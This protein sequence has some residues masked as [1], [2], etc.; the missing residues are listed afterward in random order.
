MKY[1]ALADPAWPPNEELRGVDCNWYIANIPGA[2]QVWP[3]P[4]PPPKSW[5]VLLQ[6]MAASV[7]AAVYA[8]NRAIPLAQRL[9]PHAETISKWTPAITVGVYILAGALL[10]SVLKR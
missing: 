2:R 7:P 3:Y 5:N 8:A 4:C 9:A 6:E 10:V 1:L